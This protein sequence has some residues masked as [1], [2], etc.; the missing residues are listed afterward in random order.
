MHRAN[1]G[2]TIVR[3]SSSNLG[4]L[5][6]PPQLA[7]S[8]QRQNVDCT[9]V[10]AGREEEAAVRAGSRLARRGLTRRL[11]WVSLFIVLE[12]LE[13]DI[14]WPRWVARIGVT[15]ATEACFLTADRQCTELPLLRLPRLVHGFKK[16]ERRDRYAKACATCTL[17]CH[18]LAGA[19]GMA[20]RAARAHSAC[21]RLAAG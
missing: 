21:L 10:E 14:L 19:R 17:S 5:R 7:T 15:R 3:R 16:M 2:G 6:P 18:S 1:R 12:V 20:S 9:E 4:Q 11:L 13:V 8:T